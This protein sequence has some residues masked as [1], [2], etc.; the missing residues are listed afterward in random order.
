MA[1][2]TPQEVNEKLA[3]VAEQKAERE[4]SDIR[5]VLAMPE[6]RRFF[7]RVLSKSK[8]FHT[9]WMGDVNQTLVNV[10]QKEIGLFL[11]DELLKA[12]PASFTQMQREAQSQ[13]KNEEME[14]EAICRK[15][16]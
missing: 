15:K 9:P 10:G 13:I 16:S 3:K 1:D 4:Q 14:R 5:K 11:L 8:V 12:S 7:W 2:L 6:G